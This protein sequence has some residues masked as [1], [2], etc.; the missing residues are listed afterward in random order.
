MAK[1]TTIDEFLRLSPVMPVVAIDDERLACDLA[2]AFARGGI[3]VV[4]VMLRTA[5]ALRAIETIARNV[6]QIRVGAG[7]V[8]S[9]ADFHAAANAGASFAVSPGATARLLSEGVPSAQ[10]RTCPRSP[11]PRN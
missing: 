2:L 9:V 11:P 1:T 5:A 10:F 7:T 4:E 3:S 8:L 6:P